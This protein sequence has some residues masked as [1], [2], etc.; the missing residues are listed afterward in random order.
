MERDIDGVLIKILDLEGL[1][2]P[3]EVPRPK[4]RADAETIRRAIDLLRAAK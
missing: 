2:K 4:D 1:L 3:K